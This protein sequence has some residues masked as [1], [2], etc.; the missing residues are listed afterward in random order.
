MKYRQIC[1]K[2]K[3]QLIFR[4]L[5]RLTVVLILFLVIIQSISCKKYLDKKSK[6]DLVIPS[7]LNDIQALLDYEQGM[8]RNTPAYGEGSADDYFLLKSIY[9]T[10][11]PAVRQI[12]NWTP[13]YYEFSNDW[14]ANY[15]GI[16]YTNLSLELIDNIDI[17][18]ANELQWKNVKGSAL[19]LRSFYFL[20][21]SWTF[22]KAYDENTADR[23][24]GIV[25]KLESDFNVPTI[26]ASVRES[27]NQII[28]DV[29]ESISY[30]P[31]HP[32]ITTK[33][34]KAAA[35]GLLA[36]T[37]LSMRQYDSALRYSDLSLQIK[38]Q[39]MNYAGTPVSQSSNTP[40][41]EFTL[42]PEIVFYQQISG[43]NVAF[44]TSFALIEPSLYSSYNSNDWRKTV[45]FRD[46]SGYNRYK[47]SYTGSASTFFSGIATDEM[48][49][50]RAECYAR[51][52]QT[53]DKD[54]ALSDLDTLLIK[55]WKVGT[56]TPATAAT[57]VQAL[58][59]IL[60]ERRKELLMRGLRWI[61]IKRLNKEGRNLILTRDIG[62]Q[63]YTLE[64]N[65]NHYALPL[66][67]DIIT[68][69]G[70]PQNPQ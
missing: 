3:I 9:D 70:M 8:N 29:K 66:P 37:Y 22:A 42:N 63:I 31:N 30:L 55:R 26:R 23:D 52:N 53:G 27:Y 64:P 2:F 21:L 50:T 39:L 25:L 62:G 65:A 40:F 4:S 6:N 61:D 17:T 12:Y 19:F 11:V 16:Y 48:Y 1:L 57:A 56:Y 54:L 20:Q 32:Q 44:A 7:T 58:D 18:T 60:L 38:N 13:F 47:G 15:N 59:M 68:I 34:S 35:Y 41:P 43:S 67:G 49:L 46:M 24:M 5:L 69:T 28:K 10:R 51:R 36:R 45:F 33:P 14:S